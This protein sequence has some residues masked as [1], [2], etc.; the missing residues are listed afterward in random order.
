M[1]RRM[2]MRRKRWKMRR[3]DWRKMRMRR[4]KRRKRMMMRMRIHLN[5]L[6]VQA[7]S[8]LW[9]RILWLPT[10]LSSASSTPAPIAREVKEEEVLLPSLPSRSSSTTARPMRWS[11]LCTCASEKHRDFRLSALGGGG[12]KGEGGGGRWRW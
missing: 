2:R 5:F 7:R 3:R 9:L 8:S 11:T 4:R 10:S 12:G 1:K 6:T